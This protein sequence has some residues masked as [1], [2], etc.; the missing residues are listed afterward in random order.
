MTT[1]ALPVLAA[2]LLSVLAGCATTTPYEHPQPPLAGKYDM[3]GL[4]VAPNTPSATR[5]GWREYFGD[6]YLLA[7]LAQ[8][9]E[10]NRDLRAAMARV[11]EARALYGIQRADQ[12]PGISAGAGASRARVP[13]DLSVTGSA[14]TSSQYQAT[15]NLSAWELDF[16]GRVREL[17]EAALESY[18]ASDAA[19]RSVRISL[20]A[21]TANLY[22]L[23]RELDERLAT[24]RQALS[25]REEAARILRRRYEVGAASK[26]DATQSEVLLNQARSELTLLER[27]REQAH[28]ALVLLVGIPLSSEARALSAVEAGFAR[29]I[30]P[31][32]PSDLLLDRPDVLAAEHGLKAAHANVAAAR[33]AFFPRIV[34]TGGLGS[35]SAELTGLFDSGSGVW[36]LAPSFSLPIFDGGRTQANLD[37][38]EARR[39]RSVAEYE[40]TVQ[41]AFREV[42]D[43][44]ADRRWL[45]RQVEVQKANLATQTERVRLSQ[46]G[47]SQK[48]EKIV[49]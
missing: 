13:A 4:V 35:A 38:A 29:D 24:A 17:K 21:Q 14:L 20:V 19:R 34:L 28:N 46:L 27:Q 48:T 42:A 44:L 10:N 8:S 15:L 9:L 1:H 37:L 11:T 47:S 25:T 36:S 30:A 2:V 32:L 31:G 3:E 5:L 40:R 41:S 7:L 18:L 43:A 49:R 12:L 6:P 16:W 39:H 26:L 23:E 33:A 22:L 45:A